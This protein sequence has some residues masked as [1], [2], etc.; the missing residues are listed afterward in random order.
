MDADVKDGIHSLVQASIGD[1]NVNE[2]NDLY[3]NI[4]LAGG[5]TLFSGFPERLKTMIDE[6]LPGTEV[7]ITTPPNREYSTWIGGSVMASSLYFHRMCIDSA[8]YDEKGSK[9][10]QYK[11]IRN[12]Q[13]WNTVR[14]FPCRLLFWWVSKYNDSLSIYYN[15]LTYI[16]RSIDVVEPCNKI[17]IDQSMRAHLHKNNG[18]ICVPVGIHNRPVIVKQYNHNS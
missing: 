14:W 7:R 18:R 15:M 6:G 5:N 16:P 4:L 1:C 17:I 8:E 12:T 13:D 3:D 9:I 10:V 11:N 2:R